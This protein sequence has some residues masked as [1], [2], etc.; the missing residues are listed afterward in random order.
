MEHLQQFSLLRKITDISASVLGVDPSYF[1]V[2]NR[3]KDV[4]D[5]KRF[6]INIIFDIYPAKTITLQNMAT[7]FRLEAHG[8]I[9][10]SRKKHLSFL[11]TD[12]Q[13]KNYY[14]EFRKLFYKEAILD[15]SKNN[16]EMFLTT[17]NLVNLNS[18]EIKNYIERIDEFKAHL[19]I[20]AEV[21]KYL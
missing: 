18:K 21:K 10:N 8:T 11:K 19:H 5:C 3:T 14:Q 12:R 15:I 2:R 1:L 16:K 7:F 9:L 17:D 4:M 6:A 20:L 13:Y